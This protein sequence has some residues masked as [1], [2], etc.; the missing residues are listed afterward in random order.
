MNNDEE[1]AKLFTED[2][3]LKSGDLGYY[4]DNEFFYF[5]GRIKDVIKVEGIVDLD[6]QKYFND[7]AQIGVIVS[8]TE[9]ENILLK[10]KEI[11]NA[12][13][14]A[15]KSEEYDEIPLAFVKLV[16]G[17]NLSP[18]DIQ[19][20]VDDQVNYYKKLRGGVRLIDTFPLTVL[21]K[22]NKKELKKMITNSI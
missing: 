8:P 9:L 10:N 14:I 16:N 2:G 4:D 11:E 1:N 18:E 7:L 17:S 15:I 6:K 20:F 12:A 22:I 13:V 5:L 21:K 3:F 19:K